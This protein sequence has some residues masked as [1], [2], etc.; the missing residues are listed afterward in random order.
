MNLTEQY[1]EA[2]KLIG[3]HVMIKE[4]KETFPVEEVEI[5]TVAT[6]RDFRSSLNATIQ[7]E[8]DGAAI[9]LFGGD[10]S[11][12]F[13]HVELLKLTKHQLQSAVWE[14]K[15]KIKELSDKQDAAF[16]KLKTIS[17]SN[18]YQRGGVYL[19]EEDMVDFLFDYCYNENEAT[20][21][22]YLAKFNIT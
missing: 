4:S 9:V 21:G 14:T 3:K 6:K 5:V 22:E 11:A 16:D 12:C 13:Q 15:K 18:T 17:F 7:V 10:Y 19:S 8:E 2:K 1:E 20:F